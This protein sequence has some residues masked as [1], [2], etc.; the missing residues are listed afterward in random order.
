MRDKTK[1]INYCSYLSGASIDLCFQLELN[2]SSVEMVKMSEK[3][4]NETFIGSPL[5]NDKWENDS[6][7]DYKVE[8]PETKEV[9]FN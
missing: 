3:I 4:D 1:V 2:F 5:C 8:I 9:N 7:T 6:E